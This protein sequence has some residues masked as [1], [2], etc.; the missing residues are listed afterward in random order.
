MAAEHVAEADTQI[1]RYADMRYLGQEHTVKVPVP[2]GPLTAD[3]I[4][5][6]NEAFHA[7]HEHYYTFRLDTAIEI[8]NYHVTVI[9]LVS[10]AQ[11]GTVSGQGTSLSRARKGTRQVIF[12]DHGALTTPIYERD[13]L[14]LNKVI[15]GPA[16]IEEPDSS[17]VVFPDQQVQRDKYGF[18]HIEPVQ[19]KARLGTSA[20]RR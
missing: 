16:V 8:V 20:W 13:L 15:E 1:Q 19:Q 11:I 12:D 17:T 6:I 18:L 9:G 10:K 3:A 14:P 7:L 5:Q 2:N 4:R